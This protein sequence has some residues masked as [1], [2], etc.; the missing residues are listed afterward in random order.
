[1]RG[2]SSGASGID[3]QLAA[4]IVRM[5]GGSQRWLKTALQTIVANDEM[6]DITDE[7]TEEAP[8]KEAPPSEPRRKA[9]DL[10][11]VLSGK[12]RLEDQLAEYPELAEEMEGLGDIIDL[13][14][15]AGERRRK[16]GRD[17]LR[18]ELLGEEPDDED[19]GPTN[20]RQP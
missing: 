1:M 8:R 20:S 9:P 14:R 3:D 5:S 18:E 12:A 10:E 2:E 4:R 6:L 19:S 13:L 7:V 16:R 15:E 17:I 11:D